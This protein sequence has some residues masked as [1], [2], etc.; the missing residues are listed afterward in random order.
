MLIPADHLIDLRLFFRSADR[1]L[2]AHFVSAHFLRDRLCRDCFLRGRIRR[3]LVRFMDRIRL[4]GILS[5]LGRCSRRK[6]LAF[7]N[8]FFRFPAMVMLSTESAKY[9][10]VSLPFLF[11]RSLRA[12]REAG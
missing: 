4:Q 11:F 7:G 10:H 2:S 9:L 5:G 3:Y 8:R 1:F 12:S 6:L